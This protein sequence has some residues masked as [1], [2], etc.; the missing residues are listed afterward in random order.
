[1]VK[2]VLSFTLFL[3]HIMINESIDKSYN[4]SAR[5]F[6]MCYYNMRSHREFGMKLCRK[7][8]PIDTSAV[9]PW[10]MVANKKF[11]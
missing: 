9:G 5:L 8:D 3:P 10:Q 7:T 1:M 2:I 6:L 4:G 11:P